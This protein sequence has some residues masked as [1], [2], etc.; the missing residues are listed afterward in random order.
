ML[1]TTNFFPLIS[2]KDWAFVDFGHAQCPPANPAQSWLRWWRLGDLN[3]FFWEELGK[4][5]HLTPWR[6]T[7]LAGEVKKISFQDYRDK[8]DVTTAT[9]DKQPMTSACPMG[10]NRKRAKRW[11][12]ML[13]LPLPTQSI[14]CPLHTP[15]R[16]VS[17]S[18]DV[19]LLAQFCSNSPN[20]R[21]SRH[22]N[23]KFHVHKYGRCCLLIPSQ[24]DSHKAQ[25]RFAVW[26]RRSL[27]ARHTL[28]SSRNTDGALR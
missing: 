20:H 26:R 8:R 6:S 11:G 4:E 22:P 5:I 13:Y 24:Q 18:L 16:S 9:R 10:Q 25:C 27:P 23:W 3:Q 19:R 15:S 2:T 28:L 1:G 7:G 12:N 17:R 21:W 14:S